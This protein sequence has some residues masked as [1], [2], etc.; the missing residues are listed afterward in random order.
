MMHGLVALADDI[1]PL[2]Q[3]APLA[4]VRRSDSR[5]VRRIILV[6]KCAQYR[7][8]GHLAR[9]LQV[10]KPVHQVAMA[11]PRADAVAFPAATASIS[12]ASRSP[13]TAVAGSHRRLPP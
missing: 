1:E 10:R 5:C 12:I 6:T 8:R 3:C 2:L 7:C 11:S 4:R 13:A 9:G